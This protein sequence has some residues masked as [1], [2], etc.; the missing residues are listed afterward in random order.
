MSGFTNCPTGGGGA[1]NI[2]FDVARAAQAGGLVAIENVTR[3]V[4]LN[5]R[6]RAEF[7][8][9]TANE[10]SSVF[11]FVPLDPT[12]P[13]H[14]AAATEQARLIAE[15]DRRSSGIPADDTPPPKREPLTFCGVLGLIDSTA[16]KLNAGKQAD[17]RG[18][19]S[20]FAVDRAAA[21]LLADKYAG[22]VVAPD[23]SEIMKVLESR[24]HLRVA[25]PGDV[26]LPKGSES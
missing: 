15:I 10:L 25:Q 14:L 11:D 13:R 23:D 26:P 3:R 24:P 22:G 19:V 4:E 20:L 7:R 1:M 12:N 2:P 21:V 8:S 5:I 9:L 16:A 18:L 6:A 17:D